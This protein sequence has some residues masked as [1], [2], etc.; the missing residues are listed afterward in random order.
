METTRRAE[1]ELP[2]GGEHDIPPY[3]AP[4]QQAELLCSI[5]TIQ[6]LAVCLSG[7]ACGAESDSMLYLNVPIPFSSRVPFPSPLPLYAYLSHQP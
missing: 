1:I 2:P 6:F 3:C 4:T 5:R 7:D